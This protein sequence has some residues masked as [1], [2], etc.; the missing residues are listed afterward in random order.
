MPTK[1]LKEIQGLNAEMMEISKTRID[2]LVKPQGSLGALEEIA[3]QLSGIYNTTTPK[4][5]K[6]ALIVMCADNGVCAEDIASAPPIVTRIQSLNIAGGVSGV[7]ALSK[8]LGAKVYTVDIGIDTNDALP[9]LIDKKIMCGT[10]NIATSCAMTYEQATRAIQVG[11]DMVKLAVEDGYN[12]IATGEMGIGNTTTSTAILSILSGISPY[13]LTGVGANYPIEKL[14]HKASVIEKAITSKNINK[15]DPIDIIA[16]VGGLDIAG[17]T[18]IMLGGAIYRVPVIVDGYI[19][20]V[21]ALLAC[22]LEPMVK[23]FLFP[24]HASEEKSASLATKMLGLKPYL[25]LGMRLG[26]GS[27]AVLAFNILESACVMINDMI[28]FE[29]AGIGVV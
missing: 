12:L 6:K 2:K 16:S 10:H 19:S 4:I 29:E 11:I 5:E 3:I 22:Q 8:A 20:T 9:S 18:G 27:G 23:H 15:A 28:T 17:I 25:N 1:L 13:A 21:S 26:E 24:S 7:G 14:D